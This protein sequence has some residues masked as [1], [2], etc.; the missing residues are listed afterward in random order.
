MTKKWKYNNIKG[1]YKVSGEGVIHPECNTVVGYVFP[2]GSE[3]VADVVE[4]IA[5]D[6]DEVNEF[7]NDL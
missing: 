5:E 6:S 2:A 3:I 4:N 1:K 7:L